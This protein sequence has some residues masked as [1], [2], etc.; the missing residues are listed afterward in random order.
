ML[1]FRE[2]IKPVALACQ[3][4]LKLAMPVLVLLGVI[5]ALT[6]IW[7]L[8]PR[9]VWEGYQPLAELSMRISA[10]A[11]VILVPLLIWALLVHRRHQQWEAE[12]RQQAVLDGD[13]DLHHLELQQRALD[14]SLAALRKHMGRKDIYQLPWY[15]V[16]GQEG[17]GKTSLINRFGQDQSL[18]DITSKGL[19]HAVDGEGLAN[20]VQW[21]LGN[22]A[23]LIDAPGEFISQPMTPGR[24]QSPATNTHARLWAHLLTWLGDNRSRRAI[25]GIVLVLDITRLLSQ[26]LQERKAAAALMR[27][28]LN[29]LTQQLGVRLPLYVV[30]GKV[31][32]LEGFEEFFTRLPLSVRGDV[33]GFTFSL[34]SIDDV[35]AWLNEFSRHYVRFIEQFNEQLM[36]ALSQPCTLEQRHRLLAVMRQL[37][38]LCGV[39]RGFLRDVLSSG[40][41]TMPALVRGVYFTSVYQKGLLLNAFVDAAA[42]PHGLERAGVDAKPEGGSLVYFAQQLFQRVIY[43][44][45][46]LAGDN[47]KVAQSKRRL[48]VAGFSVATL[49]CLVAVGVW[50]FYF[51]IN[52]DK[53][54]SVLAKSREFSARDIDVKVDTTGRN[55]LAPLDQIRDA[56]S[57]YGDYREAW[58][59]LS[60]MGLYQGRAI[61]PTVD[62]AYLNLLSKRFLPAIASGAIEAINAAPPGSNQQLAAL[63]VYR[64]IE[65]RQNRRPAMVEDWVAKQWQRA[66]PGQGQ[67]QTDLM[68]HLSY[69]LKYADADLPQYRERVAEVQQQLRKT[70]LAERVYMSMKQEA[71]ERLHAPL[72]LRNEVG[73]A[74]DIVYRPVTSSDKGKSEMVDGAGLT[75]ASLLT[76]KGFKDYFEPS[77]Q[78]VTE[79]AMIDQWV[80]GER[81]QLDYSEEDRKVLTARIRA[82]YSA[83]YV[84]SWRRALNQFSVTDFHD[85]THGVAVLEQ[86]TG[87]AAP[88]RR[89]LETLRDNTVIYPSVALIEGQTL[90]DAEKVQGADAGRQQ[91][92]GIRRAF[93]GLSELLT[94]KGE[95]PSYYDETLRAVSAVYDYAKG[96]QDHSDRGKAALKTVLSRFSLGGPDPIATLQRIA[97]GLPEPLN[98]QVKKLADQTSQVLVIEALRELEKRWDTEIYSFYRERL[99][100]RYPFKAGSPDDASL[101]DFEAFFGHQGRLQ[102]FHDQYLNVFIKDNLDALYSDSRGGY[103]VRSDV[104]SQLEM[105]NRIRDTFF[106][107]RGALSVQLTVEP[108]ALSGNRLSSLLSVDG[109]L[110]PYNHG[111]SQSTGLVWPN[112]LGDVSGSQLT[113][114]NGTGNTASMGYR[115][116]WSLFRLLS[117][118]HLNGRT[119]TSVDLTFVATDGMMRYRIS[120]EKANNPITQRS[121]EGF[122]LPR[123]LLQGGEK[124]APAKA[125]RT[126]VSQL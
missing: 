3:R 24:A 5:L 33:F 37:S 104:L 42:K 100:T 70:P 27:S 84:D 57:V 34:Q 111:P 48:L 22:E 19:S 89:L 92:A 15:L 114:V 126:T 64:M 14:E 67:L 113:L 106:N 49:G 107:N 39:L 11:V 51:D 60:D 56:V 82:L 122:A 1:N 31:D 18:I 52:R 32:L 38:G 25:N 109:Q 71:Q 21:W 46:G 75:L 112:T 120:A 12:R 72:D 123:T 87:P 83:D 28:R 108:L 124:V 6:G 85:L 116:P 55:L 86:V 41:H 17:A 4:Q 118:G 54:V 97:I 115:G 29:E 78:D 40:R 36:D 61:G 16:L 45:A 43:P 53:A 95:Q 20:S 69:A 59:L 79:L 77:T 65:E 26:S 58:P 62:K 105:A 50:Q 102:Q 2:I 99:A 90:A 117:R 63:R 76:A 8:G 10:S 81:Q 119:A 74:F 47:V 44:E 101:E 7:W 35:D 93:V 103:L 23:V 9:W 96:V 80:L 13:P 68:R 94:T 110:I 125:E 91:A 121:F 98:Q 30:L 88:L 66:Y 73:P